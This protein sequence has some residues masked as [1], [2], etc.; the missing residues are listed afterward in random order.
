MEWF[1]VILIMVWYFAT[2]A[3]EGLQWS[4]NEFFL[5]NDKKEWFSIVDGVALL[6]VFAM[7][8]LT[9]TTPI[10]VK[11]LYVAIYYLYVFITDTIRHKNDIDFKIFLIDYHGLRAI[12]GLIMFSI[13]LISGMSFFNLCAWWIIGNWFYK[14]IMNKTMYDTF[15]HKLTM[16]KFLLVG[17]PLPYSD[18]FYDY[19]LILP[20]IYFLIIFL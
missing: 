4:K 14:R 18:R 9:P 2:G 13:M 20:L 8:I 19:S 3:R 17:Y 7:F 12:E 15:K 5:G 6:S 16:N 1:L 11:M 10:F